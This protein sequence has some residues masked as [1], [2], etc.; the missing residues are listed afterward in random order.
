MSI[1]DDIRL[2]Q[3]VPFLGLLGREA[4]RILAI[5]AESRTVPRGTVLFT[6]G[7]PADGALVVEAGTVSLRTPGGGE[8]VA[9]RGALLGEMALLIETPRPFTATTRELTSVM[10]VARPLFLKMLDGYPDMAERL[11][12]WLLHECDQLSVEIGFVRAALAEQLPSEEQ[13]A[14]PG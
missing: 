13:T 2:L 11:R 10:R 6:A 4:L 14:K 8:F 9:R 1:E 3:G 5:G 12:Q 7:E